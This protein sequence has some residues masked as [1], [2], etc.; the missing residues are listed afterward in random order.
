MDIKE[1]LEKNFLAK[2]KPDKDLIEKEFSEAEYDLEKAKKAFEDEDYKWAIIKSYYCIFHAARAVLFKLGLKEKRHFA[3]GVVLEDLNKNGKLE[4]KYVNEFNA[5][6]SSR[7]DADYHYVYSKETAEYDLKI[8][9]D[10][11]ERMKDLIEALS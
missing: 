7:E 8:A 1:C 5:A 9:Q 4:S 6:I 10:F 2:T 3:V 11:L